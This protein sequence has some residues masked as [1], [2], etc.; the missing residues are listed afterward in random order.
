[1]EYNVIVVIVDL[2][3]NELVMKAAREAKATGGTILRGKG[4]SVYEKNQF[5]GIDVNPEKDIILIITE[6][7]KTKDILDSIN[8]SLRLT[9]PNCGIAFVLKLSD[10]VG[11]HDNEK[12]I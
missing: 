7:S 12:D 10:V 2:N 5:W 4:T 6:D 8:Q 1:M 11:L 9:D 3:Q